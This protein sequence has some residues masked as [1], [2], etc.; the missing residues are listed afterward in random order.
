MRGEKVSCGDRTHKSKEVFKARKTSCNGQAGI[1][2]YSFKK[3]RNGI[4]ESKLDK[5]AGI[6]GKNFLNKHTHP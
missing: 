4:Y 1:K 5:N 3:K 2:Q 6:L